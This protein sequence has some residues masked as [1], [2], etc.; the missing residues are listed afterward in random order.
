MDKQRIIE[1]QQGIIKHLDDFL[2]DGPKALTPENFRQSRPLVETLFYVSK[3][4]GV[5]IKN[6]WTDYQM[7]LIQSS[8]GPDYPS[9]GRLIYIKDHLIELRDLLKAY[10][11]SD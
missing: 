9:K 1:N 8:G 2:G 10:N 6:T 4:I 11:P 5:D 7:E 3:K